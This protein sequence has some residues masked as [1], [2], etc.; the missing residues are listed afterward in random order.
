M[1]DD[2]PALLEDLDFLNHDVREADGVT[3]PEIR[4]MLHWMP[5]RYLDPDQLFSAPARTVLPE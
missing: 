4:G 2:R 1:V 3:T 5:H